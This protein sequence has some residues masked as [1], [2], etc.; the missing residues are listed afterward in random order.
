MNPSRVEMERQAQ[1]RRT[2]IYVTLAV[3]AIGAIVAV[4]IAVRSTSVQNASD[5]PTI[6]QISVGQVAPTFAVSTTA[7]PFDLA[8]GDGKP[9]LLELF[10]TWCP[11]CQREVKVLDGLYARNGPRVNFV[12]VSASPLGVDS[13][14]AESQADVIA[15][16]QKFGVSYPIAFDPDLDVARKYLQGGFPTIVLIGKDGKILAIGSGELAGSDLQKALTA[17]SSG[18]PVNP[19]FGTQPAKKT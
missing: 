6:A 1:R 4:G 11:H 9:T 12:A 16:M 10:A 13:V 15:F 17:V 14:T 19:S 5:A 8:K 7:G 2:I 18:K 3:L